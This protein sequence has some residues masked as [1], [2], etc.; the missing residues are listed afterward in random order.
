MAYATSLPPNHHAL[1][2]T[3]NKISPSVQILSTPQPGPGSTVC[4]ILAAGVVS[5]QGDI[6]SGTRPYP[7]HYPL[8]IGTSAIGRIAAIGPDTTSLT[9]GQLV[10]IDSFIRA[11]DDPTNSFLSGI[12]EGHTTS[13]KILMAG[14]WRD[15]TYAEYAKI[16]LENAHPLDEDMLCGD[17]RYEVGDLTAISR[18][19]VPFGGL[20]DINLKAGETII[21]APAT[22][23]FG[24]AAVDLAIA[25]G[26]RVIAMGRNTEKLAALSSLSP[27]VKTVQLS[28]DEEIDTSALR[29]LG[30]I[31]AFLDLSP[32][33]A[34]SSTHVRSCVS[35]LKIG[36][37]VSLIGGAKGDF[38]VSY[39][40]AM[41]KDLMVKGRWMYDREHVRSLIKIF[42]TGL[43]RL[44]KGAGRK[45]NRFG[46]EE[47]RE[48]FGDAKGNSGTRVSTVICP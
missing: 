9:I 41:N 21:I 35:A 44:G 31:D 17:L 37:R 23:D 4:R 20:S 15:S 2:L 33:E 39:Q 34:S 8:T 16:P 24:T 36:G 38:A 26:A 12:H 48:A 45:L 22:G 11:R 47:W 19:T 46:L 3:S 5:Y 30:Q 1:V 6:Y 18:F 29:N 13:S 10:L 42:E 25:M 14:E 40:M 43:L 32:P 7:L 28:G 27:R